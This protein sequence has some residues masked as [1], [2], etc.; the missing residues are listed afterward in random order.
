MRCKKQN[1]VKRLFTTL[2]VV[3]LGLSV[4]VPLSGEPGGSGDF[5]FGL[6]GGWS[7]WKLDDFAV[8]QQSFQN[9]AQI[10]GIGVTSQQLSGSFFGA[11]D[12]FVEF[13][14]GNDHKLGLGTGVRYLPGGTYE[15]VWTAPYASY[16]VTSDLS[17]LVVPLEL[18]YKLPVSQ[19]VYLKFGAGVDYYDAAIDYDNTITVLNVPY[20]YRG[21]FKDTGIGGH[22]YMGMEFFVGNN[23]ALTV[24]AGYA[25]AELDDFR[26]TLTGSGGNAVDMLLTMEQTFFG[27]IL[28]HYPAAQPL[29][30]SYRQAEIDL[31]GFKVSAGVKFVF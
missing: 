27:E 2:L 31:S 23:L 13:D 9:G 18:Y 11:I 15:N 10:I 1:Y 28:G 16:A 26:G 19:S 6:R 3:M 12:L 29:Y 4:Q 7:N 21:K 14:L 30:T 22:A 20:F 24:D 8:S 5:G 25:F 17:T